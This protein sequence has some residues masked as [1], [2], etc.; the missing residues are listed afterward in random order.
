MSVGATECTNGAAHREQES[1]QDSTLFQ[2]GL[3]LLTMAPQKH[4]KYHS[5]KKT[6]VRVT[7]TI[8]NGYAFVCSTCMRCRL[9]AKKTRWWSKQVSSGRFLFFASCNQTWLSLASGGAMS[10][11]SP[12]TTMYTFWCSWSL[13]SGCIIQKTLQVTDKF[14]GH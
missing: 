11:P 14:F 10:V 9:D 12:H 6:A 7:V 1:S 13:S 2:L 4:F 3:R 5:H 8:Q